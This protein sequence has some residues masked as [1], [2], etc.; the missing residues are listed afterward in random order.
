MRFPPG[1]SAP[2]MPQV[3]L[4][5]QRLRFEDISHESGPDGRCRVG[6]RLEWCGR[7]LESQAD[8]LETHHGKIRASAA[9]TLE[10]ALAAA[11]KRIHFELLGVKAV[12]A[13]SQREKWL[14]LA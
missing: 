5:R 8:G 12:R 7:T 9:A 10:A 3:D 13:L 6:V 11:G 2:A 4:P 14:R 1:L